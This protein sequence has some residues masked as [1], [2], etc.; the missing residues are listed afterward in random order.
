MEG[1]YKN[2]ILFLGICLLVIT[3]YSTQKMRKDDL[4]SSYESQL[5]ASLESDFSH[6][7]SMDLWSF[8][9]I[10]EKMCTMDSD[11]VED[12]HY[13][14]GKIDSILDYNETY[15]YSTY[16]WQDGL[17]QRIIS[18]DMYREI[19]YYTEIKREYLKSLRKILKDSTIHI[20]EDFRLENLELSKSLRNLNTSIKNMNDR[21]EKAYISKINDTIQV[22]EDLKDKL[23]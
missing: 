10:I 22:I 11:S 23:N 9:Q 15:I 6:Y 16:T 21:Q 7:Y 4:N 12:R 1:K 2:G 5:F 14:I 13:L 18:D 20:D 19:S 8:E 3:L 17:T